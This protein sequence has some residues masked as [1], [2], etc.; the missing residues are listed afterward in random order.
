MRIEARAAEYKDI[1]DLRGLYRLEAGCQIVHDS[2]P[3]RGL[4]DPYLI[5]ADGRLAGYGAVSNKYG[6]GRLHEFHTLP[7]ARR[8][9]LAMFR[10]LL[11][12]S[13]ATHIEA[14]SNLPLMLAMLYDC[15]K[16]IKSEKIL[17]ADGGL[18]QLP[19]P[20]GEFRDGGD[21]WVIESEGA[22]VA[23]GGVLYH[24]NPPFGDI[25]M[26]VEESHRRR[27]FGG[28]IVQELKRVCYEAGKQP[29]ARCDVAN[30]ASRRTV[31]KAG[32]QVCGRLLV[33]RVNVV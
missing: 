27:G 20:G 16:A 31:E 17:F 18:T 12:V 33:G 24:Y 11:A 22:K 8:V 29:A 19:C 5:L 1:A 2:F 10:E 26:A 30:V 4:S 15:G 6:K 7:W 14:Q 3:G 23:S 28:Y 32:M 13:G 25:Y 21:E 9:A